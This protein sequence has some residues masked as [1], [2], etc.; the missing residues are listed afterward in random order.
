MCDKPMRFL[1]FGLAYSGLIVHYIR[2]R[3]AWRRRKA[4]AGEWFKAQRHEALLC[5]AVEATRPSGATGINWTGI[6]LADG[7]PIGSYWS[8]N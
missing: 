8:E 1:M 5:R 7:T 6:E 3:W 2:R 4:K